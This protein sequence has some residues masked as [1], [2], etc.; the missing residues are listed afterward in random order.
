MK[1]YPRSEQERFLEHE[2]GPAFVDLESSE[3]SEAIQE[4]EGISIARTRNFDDLATN[5]SG[6]P[7]LTPSDYEWFRESEAIPTKITEI[8]SA[9]N[10]AYQRVGLVRN[11]IDLMGD[12]ACQG[13]RLTHPNRRIQ[14]FYEN[15]WR[16]VKGKERS[17]RFLNNLFRLANVVIRMKTAKLDKRKRDKMM[18]ALAA[19]DMDPLLNSPQFLKAELPWQYTFLD[20]R[21][22]SINGGAIANFLGE[23]E[24]LL[25]IPRSMAT[26]VQKTR[27]NPNF[28]SV[29]N[30]LPPDIRE[31][32]EN[33]AKEI[34]LP[35]DKTFVYH[36]KK[37]DWQEWALPMIYACLDDIRTLGKLK[38]ADRA[39]LDGAISKIRVWKLGNIDA[40][41]APTPAAA[42]A[43]ANILENNVGGGTTD[44][45]WGPDIELI[46]SDTN[47][48]Q[49]L[50]ETKYRPTLLNIYACLGIPPTLTGSFGASGTTNNMISLKTLTER[51]KYGRGIL[52]AFWESQLAI[53][54]KS[55]GFRFPAMVEFD[56]MNLDDPGATNQL[57][58]NLADRG[59]IS[60]EF[61]QKHVGASPDMERLRI[62]RENIDRDKGRLPKKASPYHDPDKE[63]LLV[64]TFAQTGAVT[65]SEVGVELET[66]KKG[67]KTALEQ[68]QVTMQSKSPS[69]VSTTKKPG[70]PGRPKNSPD[71]QPRKPRQFTPR[72]RAIIELW[73][74]GAQQKI[75][76]ILNPGFLA[77]FKKK[78]MRSLTQAEMN[79][80]E[81]I[82]F[83]V[84]CGLI[85]LEEVDEVSISDTLS[86]FTLSPGYRV[87]CE[88][89]IQGTRELLERPLTIEEVRNV[90]A[91]YYVEFKENQDGES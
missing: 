71:T 36:Y 80:S 11:V 22:V 64:R 8:L 86:S 1:K 84:L 40:K 52:L 21:N 73:A 18:K 85:P 47:V 13:I 60:D 31:A 70:V 20:P 58:I 12:F 44:L 77:Q 87:E 46:E 49:F 42:A 26:F 53:L 41:L 54:Q 43:L 27:N 30:R 59:V 32:V 61:I 50:G 37:D 88:S 68:R 79:E 25:K 75:S 17:E 57:L 9:T 2:E 89:W 72:N 48:H 90:R 39:A 83:E 82:K 62:N 38:L 81:K 23:K 34:M 19:P 6:R 10:N 28:K 4:F 45:V 63:D 67:E 51:L 16:Q 91:N 24:Y 15:W 35:S 74:R 78:N 3:Y 69:K 66:R 29:I 55:L 5:V 33:P 76:E 56:F 65:P 7:G 14:R